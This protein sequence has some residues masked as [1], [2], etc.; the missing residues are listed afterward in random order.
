MKILIATDLYKPT[1]NG[2]VTSVLNLK[3]ALDILGHDTKIL[4]L[5]ERLSSYKTENVWLNA[6]VHV[7]VYPQARAGVIKRKY[8]KEIIDWRPDV[9]HTQ[10]EFSTFLAAKRLSKILN[11]PIVHTYHTVYEDYTHYFCP[12]KKAGKKIVSFLTRYFLKHTEDVIAPTNKVKSLLK[13]YGVKQP[14]YVLPTGLELDK[15]SF[16]LTENEKAALKEKHNIPKNNKI[17]IFLGRLAKEKNIAELLK[18]FKMLNRQ[19]VTLLIAGG[20]PYLGELKKEAGNICTG[21]SVIFTDMVNPE[22]VG[23]YYKLGDFFVSASTSETQGLTYI[24]ALANGLPA[25][26]RKDP[27][28]DDVVINNETGYQYSGYEDFAVFA[29]KLLNDT[30]F[31]NILS[32]NALKKAK[33]FSIEAFGKQAENIYKQAI[34][35]FKSV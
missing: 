11:V 18:Y 33:G 28:I 10:A 3:K 32:Q 26:C 23:K 12:S 27:C 20:G 2:V 35:N 8:I 15:F 30:S 1:V 6:S 21:L 13:S 24:E 14:I 7:P 31:R 16:T 22:D 5:S 9:I 34:Q 25:L 19:D 29:N 4:T 17:M